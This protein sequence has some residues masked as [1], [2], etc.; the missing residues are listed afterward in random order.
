MVESEARRAASAYDAFISYNAMDLPVVHRLVERLHEEGFHVFL[1]DWCLVA[2]EPWQERQSEALAD[3]S[4]CLVMCG[5]HGLGPWQEEEV[6]LAV[7]ARVSGHSLRV[8]PVL[9]P[10]AS[11]GC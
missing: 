10:G 7:S 6:R 3:S 1:D 4:C 8:I 5:A 9:L 2:G 11:R